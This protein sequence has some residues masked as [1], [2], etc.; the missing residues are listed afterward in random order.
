MKPKTGTV[1]FAALFGVAGAA[2]ATVVSKTK[3]SGSQASLSFFASTTL[4]CADGTTADASAFGS[5]SGAQNVSKI[6]GSGKSSSNGVNVD[7]FAFSNGCK[8]QNLSLSGGIANAFSPPNKKLASAAMDGD[9]FAQDF[10]SGVQVVIDVDVTLEG[11][12]PISASSSSSHTKTAQGPEG[13]VLITTTRSANSNRSATATGTLA[14]D[15]VVFPI[16]V[17]DAILLSNHNSEIDIQK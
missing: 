17:T 9:G 13:P 16:D 3:F 15:G 4:T 11:T 14:I 1:L 10:D 2:H 6:K 5:L 8:G 7:V 12:G